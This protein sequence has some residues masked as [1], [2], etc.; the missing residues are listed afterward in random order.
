MGGRHVITW[1]RHRRK[2]EDSEEDGS[3]EAVRG[4]PVRRGKAF[5][6][7]WKEEEEVGEEE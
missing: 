5:A 2:A 3:Y 6:R 7:R 4:R 1:R